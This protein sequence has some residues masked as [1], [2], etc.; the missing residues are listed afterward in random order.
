[1]GT[2]IFFTVNVLMKRTTPTRTATRGRFLTGAPRR[3]FQRSGESTWVTST[4]NRI[5]NR[6]S[7]NARH[8]QRG[9]YALIPPNGLVRNVIPG[10]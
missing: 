1:M 4:S 7:V 9:N 8:H 3:P 5:S 6:H 2:A 10:F